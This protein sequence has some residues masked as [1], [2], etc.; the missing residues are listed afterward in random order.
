MQGTQVGPQLPAQLQ[1]DAGGRLVEHEQ[2]WAVH[3]RAGDQQAPTHPAR[4][5]IRLGA[6]FRGQ[7]EHVQQLVGSASCFQPWHAEVP[8]VVGEHL[9]RAQKPV[10]VHICGATPVNSLAHAP[11]ETTS[12]P[13]TKMRLTG[14]RTSPD[15][16][17]I[18]VV[19]PEPLGPSS[20][21]KH[22]AGMCTESPCKAWVPWA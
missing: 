18:S 2:P 8:P 19:L 13:K 6:G 9:A 21:K 16:M 11:S 1:V 15:N 17:P 22:P 20:P 5:A 10:E 4:Q 3:E 14:A 12:Q 7:V